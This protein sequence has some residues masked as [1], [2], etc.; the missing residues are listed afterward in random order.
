MTVWRQQH[1]LLV[2]VVFKLPFYQIKFKPVSDFCFWLCFPRLLFVVDHSVKWCIAERFR[3]LNYNECIWQFR[4]DMKIQGCKFSNS[5][6]VLH[7]ASDKWLPP[8]NFHFNLGWISWICLARFSGYLVDVNAT[9]NNGDTA[10]HVASRLGYVDLVDTLLE[11]GAS[12]ILKGVGL[13]WHDWHDGR[14]R[15]TLIFTYCSRPMYLLHR[16][17]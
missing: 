16:V 12:V 3:C 15:V 10:L 14:V 2:L 13:S 7:Q 1:S 11:N 5:S 8:S 9:T 17:W 6:S 4:Q